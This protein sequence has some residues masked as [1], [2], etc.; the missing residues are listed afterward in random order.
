MSFSI[1]KNAPSFSNPQRQ[2]EDRLWAASGSTG[3]RTGLPRSGVL[4]GLPD[5]VG[6]FMTPNRAALPM[7]KDK[8]YAYAPSGRSSRRCRWRR[9][10]GVVMVALLVTLWYVGQYTDRHDKAR[11]KLGEWGLVRNDRGKS[12]S[13][14]HDWE[15]RRRRVVEAMRLS[16]GAY[17][18]YAWGKWPW[19]LVVMSC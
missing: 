6:D 5:R 14:K 19:Y 1:P 7:Y 18:R 3:K 2:L 4:G 17:E 11:E 8:P 9:W 13:G 10:V 16:W 12:T 15:E